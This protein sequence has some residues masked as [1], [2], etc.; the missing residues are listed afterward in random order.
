MVRAERAGA[1]RTYARS[2]LARH[3][4]GARRLDT[5]EQA[6]QRNRSNADAASR[7][8]RL[9]RCAWIAQQHKHPRSQRALS[10]I[11]LTE[12]D[13]RHVGGQTCKMVPIAEVA[14]AD[15]RARPDD[16]A[17]ERRT[18]AQITGGE[19]TA[20][21]CWSCGRC[22]STAAEHARSAPLESTRGARRWVGA[23]RRHLRLGL[24]YMDISAQ[25]RKI[26][27]L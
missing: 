12:P 20:D 18:E 22:S 10:D 19:L 17:R 16:Q 25:H 5:A 13:R 14:P 2:A 3:T 4:R 26:L 8:R 6:N 23:E 9:P 21:T 11:A 27:G 24:S 15:V 1:T 7:C